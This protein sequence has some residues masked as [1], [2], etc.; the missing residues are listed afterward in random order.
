MAEQEAIGLL[1]QLARDFNVRDPRKLFQIARR[2]FPDRRDLTSARAAAALRG[3]VARQILAPKPRSLGKSAAEGPNDRLQADLVD[4][5]SEH[6]GRNKYGLVVQDVFTREIATKALPDKRAETVTRAAAEIIPDLVQEEGNY[7]VT[8]D[9]GNEFQGLEAALPGGA[10][11]R[12]KDP[13]DR[14]ATA[15]VDRAI[16]TLKKDL[17]GMVARRGGGWGEHVDEAA[18][19]YNARPHQAVTVAP[20]DVETKPAA[21]FRSIR[22][23]PRSSNTTSASRRAGSGAS[24]RPGPSALRQTRRSSF[25]PQYGPARDLASFRL[26]GGP[27]HRRQRNPAQAR[28]ARA[29]GQRRARGPA[30]PAAGA[31]G[32]PT[33]PRL[34]P[35]PSTSPAHIKCKLSHAKRCCNPRPKTTWFACWSCGRPSGS[36]AAASVLSAQERMSSTALWESSPTEATIPASQRLPPTK[37]PAWLSTTSC[38]AAFP[39]GLGLPSPW[40]STLALACIETS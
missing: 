34:Q 20:E 14:N 8:T 15:V 2:E 6:R 17:A 24:R 39:V 32:G 1:E 40:C 36:I 35:R 16:Q 25:Q 9:L 18:E 3:D 4:F 19:A 12:Q 10:V 22:T 23:T 21:T 30:H 38:E 27:R 13:S 11:H 5:S 28:T 29:A 7:V 26:H 37:K 31:L 33:A